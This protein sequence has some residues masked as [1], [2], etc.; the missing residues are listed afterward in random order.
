[1]K[2]LRHSK[3]DTMMEIYT[4]VPSD[5][6]QRVLKWLGESLDGGTA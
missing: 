3:I 4:H 6:T 1:M 5:D 2:I